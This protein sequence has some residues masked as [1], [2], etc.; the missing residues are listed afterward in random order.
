MADPMASRKIVLTSEDYLSLP[1]DRN[2]YEILEGELIM[3]PSPTT[4]HQVVS[5]N[6]EFLL[7]A[8]VK[9]HGLGTVFDAPMDVI[10]DRT[11]VVQ[12]DI[13]FISEARRGIITE[14][15]I[16][17]APDLLVEILSP[18]TAKYDR[19]SKMQL[20][21]RYGVTWYWI[22]DPDACA[23][24][25]YERDGEAYRFRAIHTSTFEPALFP[26]LTMEPAGIWEP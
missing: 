2:R 19:L 23:I 5:R 8:H 7:F 9:T 6:L 26:G 21:A 3:T 18:S 4:R 22:V 12:P 10:L 14:R 13:L 11:T 20:F 24:E 17:G 25:E 1:N 16:E 15:A